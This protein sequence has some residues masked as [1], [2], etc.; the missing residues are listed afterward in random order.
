MTSMIQGY[1]FPEAS[2]Q[3]HPWTDIFEGTSSQVRGV[4]AISN[5]PSFEPSIIN[6]QPRIKDQIFIG[7]G[8]IEAREEKSWTD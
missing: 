4:S 6:N 3:M 1:R 7:E 5:P 8:E 2:P